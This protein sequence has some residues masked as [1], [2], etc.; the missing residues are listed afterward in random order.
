MT[1]PKVM[2]RLYTLSMDLPRTRP[3]RACARDG[4]ADGG[5]DDGS[6]DLIRTRQA[7]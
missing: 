2:E 3:G 4:M 1:N 6:D 5:P 7:I